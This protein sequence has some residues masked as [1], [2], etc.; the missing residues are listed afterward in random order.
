MLSQQFSHTDALFNDIPC[1]P[2]ERYSSGI[3]IKHL[4]VDLEALSIAQRS[5]GMSHE[6]SAH[7]SVPGIRLY[8]NRV[9]P[10]SMAVIA[11]HDRANDLI[12]FARHI[13]EPIT[14]RYFV[15]DGNVV[16]ED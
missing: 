8:R 13:E 14:D 16:R 5:L 12:S 1:L 10:P 4:Q 3:V 6:S 2:I 15:V 11:G 7:T 9:D